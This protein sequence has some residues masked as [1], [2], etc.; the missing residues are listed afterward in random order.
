MSIGA[1]DGIGILLG[2]RAPRDPAISLP[3]LVGFVSV[4]L[5][6]SPRLLVLGNLNVHAEDE[7]SGPALEFLETMV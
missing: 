5:L 6:E 2:Y 3:E 7:T 1:R 4:V